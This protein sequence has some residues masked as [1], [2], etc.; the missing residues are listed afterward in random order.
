MQAVRSHPAHI[1]STFSTATRVRNGVDGGAATD[2]LQFHGMARI[3]TRMLPAAVTP[4]SA[5]GSCFR[6][7]SS[8]DSGGGIGSGDGGSVGAR[9]YLARPQ[10]SAL[11]L[12][13]AAHLR[14][15]SGSIR[16]PFATAAAAAGI[17]TAGSPATAAPDAAAMLQGGLVVVES[18]AKALKIQQYLGDNFT[19]RVPQRPTAVSQQ[20]S[21]VPV[22]LLNRFFRM[23]YTARGSMHCIAALFTM[24]V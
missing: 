14:P 15:G 22:D 7:S 12:Q 4:P 5:T 16:L 19:V 18:P 8:R 24:L 11:V 3:L 2:F 10:L 20:S 13:Q 1:L 6:P 21:T 23:L 9:H 17:S